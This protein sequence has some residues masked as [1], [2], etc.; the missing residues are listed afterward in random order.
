[1]DVVLRQAIVVDDVG[2][3]SLVGNAT[4]ASIP[5]VGEGSLVVDGVLGEEQIPPG[6][7]LLL[8]AGLTREEEMLSWRDSTANS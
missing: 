1:M 4:L 5:I 3:D 7:T 2:V 6:K 8:A